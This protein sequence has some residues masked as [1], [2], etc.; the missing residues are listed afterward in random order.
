M[1]INEG[2]GG[3]RGQGGQG[4]GG[5][6]GQGGGKQSGGKG[7]GGRGP[8]GSCVCPNCGETLPHEQGMPCYKMKCPKCGQAMRR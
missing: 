4:Q 8:G 5:G 1:A 7:M 6:R 2:Q 3:G